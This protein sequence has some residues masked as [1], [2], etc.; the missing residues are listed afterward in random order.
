MAL[1]AA[2]ALASSR[3][4]E[5]DGNIIVLGADGNEIQITSSGA[6][7]DPDLAHDGTKVVFLRKF[8]AA[9]Y[10][11][12]ISNVARGSANPH[13]LVKTP[14]GINGLQFNQVFSPRFSPD[15]ATVFFLV[16]YAATTQAILKVAVAK[17]EP[18]FIAAALNFE[19]V[20]AGQYRGDL[21]AQIRKAK[22]AP[23]YYEWYWLLTPEGKE[24]GIVGQDDGDVALFLEQQE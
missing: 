6:D 10:E 22:L 5:R 8:G 19:I 23:G 1:F 9:T 3:A 17:P 18:L 2:S 24:L 4:V 13:P 14:L 21:V 11:I 20:P 7:S 16:P 15:G 12:W